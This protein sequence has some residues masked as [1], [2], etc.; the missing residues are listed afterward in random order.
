M[1]TIDSANEVESN[2][3]EILPVNPLRRQV[4]K[5]RAGAGRFPPI[6]E[7]QPAHQW[8]FNRG[9]CANKRTKGTGV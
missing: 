7:K 4:T 3:G 2:Q 1:E 5:R 8:N 9:R 6:G